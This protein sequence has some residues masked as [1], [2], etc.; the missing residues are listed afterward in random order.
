MRRLVNRFAVR[1]ANRPGQL[2]LLYVNNE[3][4]RI[5]GLQSG[6]TRLFFGQ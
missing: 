2:D 6:F 4:D 3:Q 5:I 1:Y